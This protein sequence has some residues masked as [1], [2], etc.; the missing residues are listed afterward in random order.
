MLT[1][2]C[3]L[4]QLGRQ[5][6]LDRELQSVLDA[7]S[8]RFEVRVAKL[9]QKRRGRKKRASGASEAGGDRGEERAGKRARKAKPVPVAVE[10]PRSKGRS[11]K[12]K[13]ARK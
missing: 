8:R 12:G 11:G 3:S 4:S 6:G 13:T 7:E 1:P 9:L 10:K 5:L 2:S